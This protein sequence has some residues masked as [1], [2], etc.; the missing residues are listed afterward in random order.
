MNGGPVSWGSRLQRC[1]TL[2]STE[3]E[4][5]AMCESV[6]DIVWMRQLLSDLGEEQLGATDLLCDNQGAVK[7]VH[8]NEYHRRT[9]HIDIK[10]RYVKE[11]EEAGTISTQYV[12]GDEQ[13]VHEGAVWT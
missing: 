10:Y 9:K 13:V 7:L 8:S 2:S 6:K 3:A 1:V 4:Y 12:Q 11:L 5:V